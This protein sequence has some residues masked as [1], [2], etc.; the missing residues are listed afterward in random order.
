MVCSLVF[1]TTSG[2]DAALVGTVNFLSSSPQKNMSGFLHGVGSTVPSDTLISQL[3]PA[4]WRLEPYNTMMYSRAVKTGAVIEIVV[5]DGYG[6]PANNWGGHGAPWE[7]NWANWE[8]YVSQLATQYQNTPVY[9]DIW[10]EPDTVSWNTAQFWNGTPAQFY[11]TYRRAYNILR[12]KLGPNAMIGGPSYANYDQAALTAFLTYCNQNNLQV[13][14]LTWHDLSDVDFS[15]PSVAQHLSYMRSLA[16]SMPNLNVR[17]IILNET[18]GPQITYFP[19]DILAF[20]YYLEKGG[21]D[22]ANRAC[23]NDSL[24]SNNCYNNS[25]DGIVNPADGQPRAS[26]WAYKILAS[27]VATSSQSS[28]LVVMAGKNPAQVLVGYFGQGMPTPAQV[29][30]NLRNLG[31]IGQKSSTLKVNISKV[32]NNGE[33]DVP[34]LIPVGL[35][36]VGVVNG[37][38]TVTLPTANLHEEYVLT[39]IPS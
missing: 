22:G 31:A 29:T 16:N 6:Y 28:N 11:E 27:R 7:N 4:Y 23:W 37:S 1:I 14:F 19:A 20:L 10:N 38:A 32:P 13:N 18:V 25:L 17:K 9:W 8:N 36:T 30:I 3:K 24:G 15:I 21:A 39:L 33:A 12:Q 2:A 26:W 34:N 5:S 35:W